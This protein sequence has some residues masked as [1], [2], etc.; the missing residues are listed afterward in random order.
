MEEDELSAEDFNGTC[1]YYSE[2]FPDLASSP[3][4]IIPFTLVYATIFL[5][6]IAG[7]SAIIYVTAKHRTLQVCCLTASKD[8]S[9]LYKTCLY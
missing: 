6:G 9:R 4:T 7:N 3:Y 1:E 8:A 5:M 2:I